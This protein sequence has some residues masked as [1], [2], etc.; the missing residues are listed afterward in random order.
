MKKFFHWLVDL[1][2]TVVIALL[3]VVPIRLFIFQPFIVRGDSMQPNFQHNDYMIVDQ[4]S[5]RFREPRRGEVIVFNLNNQRF[6]KRIIG[7]PGEEV[8]I[9]NNQIFV[10]DKKLEEKY[11][12]ASYDEISDKIVTLKENEYFVLGD[13]RPASYDSRRFGL[14][15]TRDIV[16]K[17]LFNI[18]FFQSISFV[19]TP[20]YE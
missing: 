1:I 18:N 14:I 9:E 12:P 7:L 5:Y 3:I 16:G 20:Q 11:I 8:K 6:V 10:S 15:E 17:S 2:K 19:K 13:N 4:L